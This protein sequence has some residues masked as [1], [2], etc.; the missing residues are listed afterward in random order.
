MT[1]IPIKYPMDTALREFNE[2]EH[3]GPGHGPTGEY[4]CVAHPDGILCWFCKCGKYVH[5]EPL[6]VTIGASVECS[7]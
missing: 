6:T 2:R 4:C 3:I 1:I 5:D 7:T